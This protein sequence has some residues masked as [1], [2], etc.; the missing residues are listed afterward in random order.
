MGKVI[1][2]LII[3]AIVWLLFFGKRK[4]GQK[5]ARGTGATDSPKKISAENI[6]TCAKCGVNI[7]ES[8]AE[9][10]ESGTY[11]CRS[12]AQCSGHGQ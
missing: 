11:R 10:T 1:F 4:L 8:E 7:P 12:S 2:G 3:A 9:R 6:V 5:D